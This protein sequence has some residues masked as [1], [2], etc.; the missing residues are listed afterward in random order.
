MQRID[1]SE[2]DNLLIDP[3]KPSFTMSSFSLIKTLLLVG[4]AFQSTAY[5]IVRRLSRGVNEE[6]YSN[7]SVLLIMELLKFFF[8]LL[9][10]T[11]ERDFS[12]VHIVTTSLPLL[13]PAIGYLV[14]NVLSFIAI[15]HI[16]A[17][18]FIVVIQLKLLTTALF[19]ICIMGKRISFRRWRSLVTLTIGVT[20]IALPSGEPTS[21]NTSG[22]S[23]PRDENY[24]FGVLAVLIEVVLSGFTSVFFEST[25]KSSEMSVWGRNVQLSMWS[26]VIYTCTVSAE[27]HADVFRGWTPLAVACALLGAL[28][29]IL[30]ALALR[31]TDSLSKTIATSSCIIL[32]CLFNSFLLGE[33]VTFH[34]VLYVVIVVMAVVEYVHGA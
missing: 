20:L 34:V 7:A 16:D 25:L 17:T 26:I 23:V 19:S 8:S 21:T 27:T 31:F 15:K 1:P 3:S 28:G 2:S 29:G 14:M 4:V 18:T 13:L 22:S 12:P 9:I 32:T 10:V 6:S 5:T 24:I 30:V 11:F 33:P